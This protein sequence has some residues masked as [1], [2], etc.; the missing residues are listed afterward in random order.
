MAPIN[1]IY[2]KEKRIISIIVVIGMLLLLVI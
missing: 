2:N 1:T